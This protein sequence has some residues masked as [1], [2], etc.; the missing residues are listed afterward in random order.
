MR[1]H[2][3]FVAANYHAIARAPADVDDLAQ[4]VFVKAFFGLRL[5][6]ARATSR[7]P[8]SPAS[9]PQDFPSG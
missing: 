8:C 4:E 3:G 1:R 9:T 5:V 2:Q 7:A 6:S